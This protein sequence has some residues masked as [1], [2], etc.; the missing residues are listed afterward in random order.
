VVKK[1]SK[2]QIVSNEM[3]R[4]EMMKKNN[5]SASGSTDPSEPLRLRDAF[6]NDAG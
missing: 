6:G 2:Y 5:G 1:D 4:M 3:G